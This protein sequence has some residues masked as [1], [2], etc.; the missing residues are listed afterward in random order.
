MK[1]AVPSIAM[2]KLARGFANSVIALRKKFDRSRDIDTVNRMQIVKRMRGLEVNSSEN[3]DEKF[4][5]K[6]GIVSTR[7]NTLLRI[8]KC[9]SGRGEGMTTVT[10]RAGLEETA[11]FFWDF[12]SR[13]NLSLS[14]DIERVVE[15]RSGVELEM[16]TRRRAKLVSKPGSP[17]HNREFTNIMNIMKTDEDTIAI[18]SKPRPGSKVSRKSSRGS[19][20]GV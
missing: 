9:A 6:P 14:K 15:E 7:D 13:A 8:R 12:T 5:V 18:Q 10:F 1:G 17:H 11:A 4:K 3:F 20:F 2:N 19:L 16:L